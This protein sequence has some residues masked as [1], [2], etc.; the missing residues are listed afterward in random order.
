MSDQANPK[1]MAV[2]K[3]GENFT[4]TLADGETTEEVFV[5]IVPIS[6]MDEYLARYESITALVSF[7]VK[8]DVAWLDGLADDSLYALNRKV[9]E[10]ND[11]RFDRWVSEQRATVG[12]KL[13]SLLQQ[14]NQA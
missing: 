11:P 8:K 10:M 2:L 9:R 14:T 5:R 4:V 7:V 6:Q 3:G 1:P 13:K 12:N